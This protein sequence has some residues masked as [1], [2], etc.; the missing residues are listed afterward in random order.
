MLMSPLRSEK[1]CPGDAH[2]KLKSAD[3]TSRQRGRLHI[4]KP[5]ERMGKIDRESQMGAWHQNGL[6]D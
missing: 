5:E 2:Q 4:N 1:G 3:P 6:A